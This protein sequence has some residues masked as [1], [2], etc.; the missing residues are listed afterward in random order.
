MADLCEADVGVVEEHQ[1]EEVASVRVEEVV[2]VV[3]EAFRGAVEV[4]S[5]REEGVVLEVAFREGADEGQCWVDCDRVDFR[6]YGLRIGYMAA[7]GCYLDFI[8]KAFAGHPSFDS[9]QLSHIL[10]FCVLV[11]ASFFE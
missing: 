9:Y 6:R 3:R 11:S 5:R 10:L 7:K 8:K 2:V 4:D 1:E